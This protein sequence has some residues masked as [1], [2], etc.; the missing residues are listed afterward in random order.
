MVIGIKE[1]SSPQEL[2]KY[3]DSQMSELR[4][5]LGELLRLIEELRA[6]SEQDQRLRALIASLTGKPAENVSTPETVV[7]IEKVVIAINPS[8]STE[9][10]VMEELAEAIN[11]KI[12][13]LQNTKKALERLAA[14]G[15]EA[16]LEV[17][18]YDDVPRA[19]IIRI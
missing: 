12:T 2:L 7:E 6:K 14:A 9:L 18:L 10:R 16:K 11:N 8:P 1:F 13:R 19:V 3:I 4:R 17:I 15:I 5:K